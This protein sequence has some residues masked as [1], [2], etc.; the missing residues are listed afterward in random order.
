[1]LDTECTSCGYRE[2]GLMRQSGFAGV[3]YEPKNCVAC[4]RT[5]SVAVEIL[6][7]GGPFSDEV[8]EE[9][10]SCPRCGGAE[11]QELNLRSDSMSGPCP[12]CGG[13]L[14][15]EMAGIWD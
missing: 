8:Q 1:L 7:V 11:L 2:E 14:R 13:E 12:Q 4:R 5:V 10:N 9:L 3:L 6:D 15:F